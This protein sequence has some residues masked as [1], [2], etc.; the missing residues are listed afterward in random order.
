MS[1][2]AFVPFDSIKKLVNLGMENEGMSGHTSTATLQKE[3]AKVVH[4]SRLT[5][6]ASLI[7]G[8]KLPHRTSFL[9]A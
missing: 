1:A 3:W 2:T 9:I 5:L 4:G 7:L 8:F 6:D